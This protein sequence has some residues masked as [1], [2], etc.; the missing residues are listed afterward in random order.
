MKMMEVVELINNEQKA[1]N[2]RILKTRLKKALA[3]EFWFE[4]CMI[5]YAIIEDRASS[6]LDHCSVCKNA[7]D[8]GK[9]L[10]N[11]LR[12]I[13]NQIGKGHPVISKKIDMDLI[14]EILIWKDERN[15]VVHRACNHVYDED[16]VKSIAEQGNELVRR[17]INDSRKVSNYYKRQNTKG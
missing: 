16:K 4:A 9:L 15:E 1:E 6:I 14:R 7:Y 2:Y 11:K 3:S 13:E 12:S 8:S 5:E 10:T 17:L